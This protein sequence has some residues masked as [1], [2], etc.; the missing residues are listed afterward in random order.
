MRTTDKT[1][2]RPSGSPRFACLATHAGHAGGAAIAMERLASGLRAQG[3][4]VDIIT[5]QN[6]PPATPREQRLDRTIRRGIKRRRTSLSNTLF[7]ADWPAQDVAGHP[8]VAAADI[9][10]VHWVAGFL[11]GAGI[12]RLVESGK[13]V[14]WTLH[15]M[16]PFT[17]GCHYA[18]GCRGFAGNCH[19]CPQLLPSL[20]E[21]PARSL[22]RAR[23]RLAGLPLVFIAPS[24]WIADELE[25]STLFDARCHAVHVIPNGLDLDRYRPAEAAAARGRLGLPQDALSILLG[26]VS[27][28]EHRKGSDVAAAAV[29]RAAASLSARGSRAPVV[30]TYGSGQLAIPGVR[31]HN[32]GSLDEAGVIEALHACD[33]HLSM[34]REDNLPNTVMESLACGRPVVA[35]ATGGIPEMVEDG[36]NGWLVP[37]DDAQAAAGVLERIALNRSLLAGAGASA[38][39]RAEQAW[40]VSLQASRYLAIAEAWPLGNAPVTAIQTSPLTGRSEALTPAVAVIHRGGPLRKPIRRMRRVAMRTI[41][42][43]GVARSPSPGPTR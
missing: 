7:T 37:V 42:S 41:R 13:R 22:A 8:A 26:S 35:T 1:L 36:V 17:G 38:R 6:C 33:L 20:H 43:R 40:A 16:R 3:A 14:A 11:A 30:L 32:L 5:R 23:R 24:Q 10:N 31:C 34:A 2:T 12:R 15:D 19:A 21:V 28:S 25:C 4:T 29:A 27:L 39:S 9:V 18:A